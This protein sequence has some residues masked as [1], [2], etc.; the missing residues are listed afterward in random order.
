[1]RRSQGRPGRGG[2]R[3]FLPPARY[4]KSAPVRPVRV[5]SCSCTGDEPYR[6]PGAILRRF[7]GSEQG[8]GAGVRLER[9]DR[10]GDPPRPPAIQS[11]GKIRLQKKRIEDGVRGFS[12]GNNVSPPF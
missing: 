10:A 2:G 9:R 4:Y 8:P 7:L 11:I 1:M 3:G 12:R 6:G 5:I